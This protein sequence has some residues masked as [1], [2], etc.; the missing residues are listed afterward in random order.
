[1]H[2]LLWGS[3]DDPRRGAAES[4]VAA[5]PVCA[6]LVFELSVLRGIELSESRMRGARE[7]SPRRAP[8]WRLGIARPLP[9]YAAAAVL[10]LAIAG[11]VLAGALLARR[12]V[13][14]GAGPAG[15]GR[16]AELALRT[17]LDFDAAGIAPEATVVAVASFVEPP[18]GIGTFAAVRSPTDGRLDLVAFGSERSPLWVGSR[19]APAIADVLAEDEVGVFGMKNLALRRRGASLEESICVLLRRR[20]RSC[21]LVVDP[22]SGRVRASTFHAGALSSDR[23]PG[24]E[25]IAL[26]PAADG[27]DRTIALAGRDADGPSVL[28]LSAVG[29]VLQHVRLPGIGLF[30][31]EGAAAVQVRADWS[32]DRR[33]ADV[34]TSE[35]VIVSFRVA[36]GRLVAASRRV[37]VAD[38]LRGRYD[39][40]F[41]ERAWQRRA[42]AAGGAAA[43][44]E[45]LGRQ[46]VEMPVRPVAGW[47]D[48]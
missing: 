21:V 27:A 32:P 38:R 43:L 2:A 7:S 44:L 30:S 24:D 22:L 23:G 18:R 48:R 3:L 36:D 45:E 34:W 47:R 33:E 46:V 17:G 4:H 6:E 10:V 9:R 5:C 13:F 20:D 39:E 14:V 8:V 19:D 15:P 41:G 35:D 25:A 11:G 40:R 26:L 31:G 37:A 12:S 1:M 29:D 28:V 42:D 16:V